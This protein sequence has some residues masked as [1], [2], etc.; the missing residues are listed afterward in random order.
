MFLIFN[1]LEL[2]LELVYLVPGYN[3]TKLPMGMFP[4]L[5]TTPL[6]A[7]GIV[8]SC[9]LISNPSA[10]Y[11]ALVELP[12]WPGNCAWWHSL[13]SLLCRECNTVTRCSI[14]WE[15][16]I[17]LSWSVDDT[18]RTVLCKNKQ[19]KFN[20]YMKWKFEIVMTQPLLHYL[21]IRLWARVFYEQIV[22]EA[23]P[24]WLLL[25]ENEGE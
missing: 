22:N 24:S 11:I 3:A 1:K 9:L 10:L 7:P 25:I 12:P 20:W 23:Q 15:S 21:T 14:T 18:S 4:L 16:D 17:I 2:E 5:T 13:S 6:P 19:T 8:L